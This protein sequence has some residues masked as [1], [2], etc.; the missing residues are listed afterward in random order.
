M[1]LAAANEVMHP[2]GHPLDEYTK[3]ANNY[4]VPVD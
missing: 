4:Q 3:F 1:V 2:F